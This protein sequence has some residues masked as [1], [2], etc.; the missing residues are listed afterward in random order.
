MKAVWS[1]D[2]SVGFKTIDDQHKT[3]INIINKFNSSMLE[4]GGKNAALDVLKFLEIYTKI[5]FT[6]EERYMQEYK[7]PQ[8]EEHISQH[9]EFINYIQ[10]VKDAFSQ[11]ISHNDIL[12]FHNR[13]LAWYIEH[14]CKTDKL[15]GKFL[16]EHKAERNKKILE[17]IENTERQSQ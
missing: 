5:H 1:E 17:Y 9:K 4:G 8:I 12:E 7:Y 15:L 14:I 11:N 3:L 2:L 10:K 13:I 16:K 6:T